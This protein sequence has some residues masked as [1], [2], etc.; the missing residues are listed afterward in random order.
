[1]SNLESVEL[2][3]DSVRDRPA[4]SVRAFRRLL[5]PA[6]ITSLLIV[7]WLG[8][9]GE[10]SAI[11]A[12][13]RKFGTSC[14]T[15]HNTYPQLNAFGRLFRAQGYRMPGQGD[16]FV[17]DPQVPLGGPVEDRLWPKTLR[18]SDIP[19]SSVATFLV[20]SD[21]RVFPDRKEGATNEFDGV[22]EVALI[23][24]GTVGKAWSFFGDIDLFEDGEPGEIGRLFIQ[25][26][27]STPLNIRVGM[28]EP[29]AVPLSN[30]RR[31]IRTTGYLADTFPL[32]ASHNF[33]G[34]SPSQKGVEAF[35][36]IPGP[37]GKGEL[38]WSLG[39]VNGEH[40]GAAEVLS[41]NPLTGELLG[42]LEIAMD[43]R[44]EFDFNSEKDYYA[45][46]DYEVWLGG[47]AFTFGSYYYK[48]TTGFLEDPGDPESFLENGNSFDRYGA[49]FRW[50]Q[51]KGYFTV[52][53]AASFGQDRLERNFLNR[54]EM[55]ILTAEVQWFPYPWLVPAVRWENVE[56]DDQIPIPSNSFDRTTVEITFLPA[57]NIKLALGAVFS[58]SDAPDLPVF[59]ELYRAGLTIAF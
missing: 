13:A 45:N 35:G 1:M 5:A 12:F 28:F 30:H 24:G 27:H 17:R 20:T 8:S 9:A 31:L 34:F 39:V 37:M 40:G 36:R 23:I 18:S 33:F 16:R 52:L 51:A 42:N 7:I 29:R 56:L 25:W 58:S 3:A 53:G 41:E 57:A 49:R 22:G 44:G 55:Q 47:E 10:A 26:K 46:V 6:Q 4:A 50:E 54:L 38:E 21:F 11:P 43:D 15:C 32:V 14:S 2:R 19:G 59:A 48:G